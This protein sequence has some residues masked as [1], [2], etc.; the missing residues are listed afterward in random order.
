MRS[1]SVSIP[2]LAVVAASLAASPAAR[3]Q[4]ATAESF[5]S[6]GGM[7]GGYCIY[8]NVA[9]TVA[10]NTT[11][12][13]GRFWDSADST[14]NNGVGGALCPAALWWKF[15]N[16]PGP[17]GSRGINGSISSTGCGMTACPALPGE[18]TLLVEDW[19]P[20]GP[21]GS[22]D[23]AY[24]IVWRV[25]TDPTNPF[26]LYNYA[27][28]NNLNQ[29]TYPFL[30]FPKVDVTASARVGMQVI[31][32]ANFV[33]IAPNHHAVRLPGN[34]PIP[35]QETIVS[36]DLMKATGLADPGRWRSAWTQIATIPYSGA[37]S[38]YVAS[39]TCH[40]EVNDDWLAVG[41][42]F[43][44]GAGPDVP[45]AL[46]GRAIA[47]ECDPNLADPQLHTPLRAHP[48]VPRKPQPLHGR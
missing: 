9:A 1:W 5:A 17:A 15:S 45:S 27:R 34:T 18:L 43:D 3:A 22:G 48:P 25:D 41:V 4:C 24:F 36:L 12:Q 35:P 11:N 37:V 47:L 44:G 6:I 40:D 8:V 26:R 19:G 33:D 21:L 20:T 31:I 39:V 32:T 42:T 38:Q 30:E 2:L 13:I 28:T 14:K 46:V 10:Q 7:C 16:F 29:G 23:T